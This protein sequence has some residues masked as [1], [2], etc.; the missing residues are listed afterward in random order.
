MDRAPAVYIVASQTR[1]TIYTGVT[2][3][4]IQRWWQHRAGALDG[5]TKRYG[6][7]RLV[8]VEFFGD[9]TLAIAREKQLK[10]WRREWKVA[11]IEKSNPTWR[12]LSPDYGL[13]PVAQ[14]RS[15]RK[16]A[17]SSSA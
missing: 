12:D 13:E 8:H 5:F 7:T 2:S 4:P 14:R 10:A 1:G 6:V 17:E 16:D 3:Q 11:L 9:M 15:W